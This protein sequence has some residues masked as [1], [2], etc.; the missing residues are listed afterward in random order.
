[1]VGVLVRGLVGHVVLDEVGD[2]GD[3]VVTLAAGLVDADGLHS[4]VVLEPPCLVDVV[5]DEPPQTGVGLVQ[6]LGGRAGGQVAGHLHGPRLEQEREPAAGPGPRG[7]HRPHP[8]LGARDAGH[9]GVDERLVL[10]EVQVPP[11]TLPPVMHRAGVFPAACLGT[12]EA[13]AGLEAD[14][15]VQ[16]LPAA[17]GVTEVHGPHLPR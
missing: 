4:H 13:G 16:L 17:V 1:M 15:D 7:G 3:V 9:G 5:G 11:H 12:M 14:H 2:H 8:V 6:L 10:E